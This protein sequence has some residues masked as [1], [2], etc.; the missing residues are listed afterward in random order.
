M[1]IKIPN[2]TLVILFTI[3]STFCFGQ[4][5]TVKSVLTQS[6]TLLK[7]KS[8][9][10]CTMNYDLY[11]TSFSNEVKEHYSGNIVKNEDR[12]YIKINNTIFL[13]QLNTNTFLKLNT[14]QKLIQFL[15]GKNVATTNGSLFDQVSVL[16]NLY[17]NQS[18]KS[19]GDYWICT[20]KA[21][22]VSQLPYSKVELFVNKETKLLTKQVLYFSSQMPYK[23]KD[24]TNHLGN[25]RLEISISDYQFSL[26]DKDK[27]LTFLSNYVNTS[28]SEIRPS[29]AY[30]NFKIIQD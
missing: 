25:P 22:T 11:S 24:G 28:S 3:A 19:K 29:T 30:K 2:T 8:E 6:Q 5:P 26:T 16:I 27:G 13:N 4:S 1:T 10:K 12:Y 17:K 18:L 20:L 21:N 23:K 7:D 15:K 9:M 14:E